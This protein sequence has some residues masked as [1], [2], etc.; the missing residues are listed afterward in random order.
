MTTDPLVT[1]VREARHRISAEFDHDPCRFVAYHRERERQWKAAGKYR[2][3]DASSRK[4]TPD[5]D[6]V[7]HER[8]G[9]G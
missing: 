7:L 6:L 2:F 9:A 3:A 5:A 1:A 8:P 4:S